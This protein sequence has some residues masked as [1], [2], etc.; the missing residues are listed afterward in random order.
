MIARKPLYG[1]RVQFNVDNYL[2]YA[3]QAVRQICFQNLI[4]ERLI[5]G[6]AFFV[7]RF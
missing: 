1:L 7:N 4:R 5:T 6:Y 3:N 2:E